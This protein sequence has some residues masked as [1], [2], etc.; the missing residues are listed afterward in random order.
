[1]DPNSAFCLT[2]SFILKAV[3]LQKNKP[4]IVGIQGLQG[5]GKSTLCEQIIQSLQIDHKM[6]AVSFSLDDLYLPHITLKQLSRKYPDNPL[7]QGRGLPGTHDLKLGKEVFDALLN[8]K[9][10]SIPKYD[11][12]L[13][14]GEGDRTPQDEWKVLDHPVDVVL[15]EGWMVGFEA[16]TNEQ[17]DIQIALNTN[18]VLKSFNMHHIRQMNS[19][20]YE[21]HFFN[22]FIDA[23]VQ[24]KSL[25]I[26][27]VY[28][29]R[30]QQEICKKQGMSEKDVKMFVDRFIPA[31]VLYLEPLKTRFKNSLIIYLDADRRV[32]Q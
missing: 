22:Y 10:I 12:S 29:W 1:M 2:L 24:L 15:F 31:Y 9:H 32:V 8:G 5:S 20:L 30:S 7:L 28:T 25:D 23:I 21:Y 16:L 11:K 14:N 19:N 6:T 13:N 26:S 18:S 17:L 3:A 27:I 4:L